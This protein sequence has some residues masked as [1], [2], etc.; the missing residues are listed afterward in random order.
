MGE[1]VFPRGLNGHVDEHKVP[2]VRPRYAIGAH[3]RHRDRRY[4]EQLDAVSECVKQPVRADISAMAADWLNEGAAQMDVL[5]AIAC[6][7]SER[8]RSRVG[9]GT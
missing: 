6:P 4:G 2:T 3:R 7:L 9:T 8:R 1:G 5:F